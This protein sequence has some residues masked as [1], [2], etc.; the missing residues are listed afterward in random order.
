M[1][2][3]SLVNIEAEQAILGAL[4]TRND[5]LMACDDLQPEH[6][7]EAVHARIYE[8]TA[9]LIRAGKHASAQT[10]KTYF[11]RDETLKE[12]GGTAYLARLT[13]A[14]TTLINAPSYASLVRD[15]ALRR[16]GLTVLSEAT[17]SVSDLPIDQ[18]ADEF[19]SGVSA[20]LAKLADGGNRPKINRDG[21]PGRECLA[22]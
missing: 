4:L 19:L 14:A 8:A 6:F 13:G 21:V 15:L 16:A 11:E 18:S 12:I 17:A 10:L 7:A 22:R 20:D 5:V 2:A 9:S 1:T 3:A